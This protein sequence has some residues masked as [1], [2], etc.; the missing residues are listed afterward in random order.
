MSPE[1]DC[2]D[3]TVG[4]VVEAEGGKSLIEVTLADAIANGKMFIRNNSGEYICVELATYWKE[5]ALLTVCVA[6][7]EFNEDGQ[8]TRDWRNQLR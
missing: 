2:L 7:Y 3:V 1:K 4:I 6:G 5:N 8:T